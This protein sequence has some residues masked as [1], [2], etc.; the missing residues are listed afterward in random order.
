MASILLRD[1]VSTTVLLFLVCLLLHVFAATPENIE[2]TFKAGGD[3][4]SQPEKGKP[5][6][7]TTVKHFLIEQD[8]GTHPDKDRCHEGDPDM[9]VMTEKK[10]Q[11][12]LDIGHFSHHALS[13]PIPLPI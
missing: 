9:P 10:H 11:F 2:Q 4:E 3:P 13:L 7:G 8:P 6:S 12:F 5:G 1:N